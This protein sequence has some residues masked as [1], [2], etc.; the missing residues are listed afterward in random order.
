MV[1][2]LNPHNL[3]KVD[4]FEAANKISAQTAFTEIY[5]SR[6]MIAGTSKSATDLFPWH[7]QLAHLN[8]ASVKLL[9]TM[10]TGMEIV[11][12]QDKTPPL[13]T[14]CVEAKMT[15]QP[16]RD[17]RPHSSQPGFSLHADVGGGGQT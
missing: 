13:C 3:Y 11:Q 2:R 16:H 15:L 7:R 5:F 10:V 4:S 12:S 1:S 17:A 9:S 14:V 6:A 8:E